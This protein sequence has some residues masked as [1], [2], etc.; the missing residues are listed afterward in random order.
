MR[1]SSRQTSGEKGK[2]C[3]KQIGKRPEE[4]ET[5]RKHEIGERQKTQRL[6]RTEHIEPEH[7]KD[8]CRG[9]QQFSLQREPRPGQHQ[10]ET[11]QIHC[12]RAQPETRSTVTA[13]AQIQKRGDIQHAFLRLPGT[14][15]PEQQRTG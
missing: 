8:G 4:V 14:D 12:E 9:I 5:G 2:D 7:A 6:R 15:S 11:R 10:Y 1:A 13:G 3:E